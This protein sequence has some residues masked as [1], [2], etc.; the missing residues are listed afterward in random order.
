MCVKTAW[1][2]LIENNE[3]VKSCLVFLLFFSNEIE[4]N[5]VLEKNSTSGF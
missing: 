3:I 1:K 2:L 4:E 5:I